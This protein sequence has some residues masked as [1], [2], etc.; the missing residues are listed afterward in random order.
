[1]ISERDGEAELE[2]NLDG[3]TMMIGQNRMKEDRIL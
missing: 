1:M 2:E 3:I